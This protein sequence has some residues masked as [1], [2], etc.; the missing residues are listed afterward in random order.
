MAKFQDTRL[1]VK[2]PATGQLVEMKCST[3]VDEAGI[4]QVRVPE[5]LLEVIFGTQFDA[6]SVTRATVRGHTYL[7]GPVLA[8]LRAAL[9]KAWL[10]VL[11]PE[12]TVERVIRYHLGSHVSFAATPDGTIVPNA[13]WPGARWAAEE[14]YGE[15]HSSNPSKGG[16]SLV[17][18]A[19]V[20]DKKTLKRGDVVTTTYEWVSGSHTPYAESDPLHLLQAWSSFTLPEKCAEM[21]YSPEAA[22]FFHRLMLGMAELSRRIQEFA[23]DESRLLQVINSGGAAL[24]PAPGAA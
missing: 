4:F 9:E 7:R 17:I 22:L 12:E 13:S 15:H 23:H 2:D 19:R 10:Q 1:S 21:P 8:T 18:G 3:S 14:W 24:L 5:E 11:A 6:A 16:Y 20:Y